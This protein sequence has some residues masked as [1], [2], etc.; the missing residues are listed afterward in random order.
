MTTSSNSA[1]G[2]PSPTGKRSHMESHLL[3]NGGGA[4][5]QGRRKKKGEKMTQWYLLVLRMRRHCRCFFMRAPLGSIREKTEKEISFGGAAVEKLTSSNLAA[6]RDGGE[7]NEGNA[8]GGSQRQGRGLWGRAAGAAVAAAVPVTFWTRCRKLE[9]SA[10]MKV[11]VD[12]KRSED[13]C[14]RLEGLFRSSDRSMGDELGRLGTT[15]LSAAPVVRRL[16]AAGWKG[17]RSIVVLF[18][19]I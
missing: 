19:A 5:R 9:M 8:C 12:G 11:V 18:S 4:T 17:W 14:R 1:F 2:K 6:V 15:V 16:R 7:A 13:F 3:Y 10:V